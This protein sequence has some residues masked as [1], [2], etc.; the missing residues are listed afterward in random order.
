MLERRVLEVLHPTT[1][2]YLER[3]GV[4]YAVHQG[5]PWSTFLDSENSFDTSDEPHVIDVSDF[6]IT[7]QNGKNTLVS[8][9]GSSLKVLDMHAIWMNN[10]WFPRGRRYQ[11]SGIS[12]PDIV[13]DYETKTG[14]KIDV[15]SAC[16]GHDRSDIPE[17]VFPDSKIFMQRGQA[18]GSI[19]TRYDTGGLSLTMHVNSS[20]NVQYVGWLNDNRDRIRNSVLV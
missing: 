20:Q 14:E 6:S 19:L 5:P 10:G 17:Q 4:A 2:V 1:H 11:A 9:V 13:E 18:S 7:T 16:R 3:S 15:I 8:V 12:I